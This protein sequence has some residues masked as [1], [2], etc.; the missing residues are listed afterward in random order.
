MDAQQLEEAAIA[1]FAGDKGLLGGC[2]FVFSRYP[3]TR[4][5]DLERAGE[6]RICG[7]AGFVSPASLQPGC[8]TRRILPGDGEEMT[9]GRHA[10]AGAA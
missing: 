8:T 6:Q 5:G 4:I 3:A 7:A 10:L 1:L 9:A 2:I